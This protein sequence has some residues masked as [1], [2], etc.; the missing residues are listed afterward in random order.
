MSKVERATSEPG[1]LAAL[2][3][4]VV[5]GVLI[6]GVTHHYGPG[7]LSAPVDPLIVAAPFLIGWY[8]VGVLLGIYE[9]TPA[10]EARHSL[11]LVAATAL[12]GANV[13][14]ILRTLAFGDSAVSP[15]PAVITATILAATLG[16]RAVVG[17]IAGRSPARSFGPGE[18]QAQN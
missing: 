17:W 3:G 2:D 4:V 5:A 13:G 15:F 11:R 10:G 7:V 8:G 16:V 6:A 1:A 12:G 9:R 18:G 14:L